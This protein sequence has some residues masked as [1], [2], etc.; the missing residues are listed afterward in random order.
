MQNPLYFPFFTYENI[1]FFHSF[2]S[3]TENGIPM[4]FSVFIHIFNC[5]K[6]IKVYFSIKFCKKNKMQL[7]LSI[8]SYASL[9]SI[10]CE[11]KKVLQHQ[12][13]LNPLV[14]QH[15]SF[16]NFPA[17]LVPPHQRNYTFLSC[18]NTPLLPVMVLHLAKSVTPLLYS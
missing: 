14:L 3:M 7:H 13:F 5:E 17:E 6:W 18:Q 10:F 8:Q 12:H 15:F 11:L 16:V 2:F 9:R 1:R 4:L